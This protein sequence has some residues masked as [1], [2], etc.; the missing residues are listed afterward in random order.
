[1]LRALAAVVLLAALA[2]AP[3]VADT[4]AANLKLQVPP[5][6][7]DTVGPGGTRS[8]SWVVFALEGGPAPGSTLTFSVP[9]DV[10]VISLHGPAGAC[11]T[12]AAAVACPLGDLAVG[13]RVAVS[14]VFSSRGDGRK[15][16]GATAA[17]TA[18]EATPADNTGTTFFMVDAGRPQLTG[19]TV[20]PH[21]Y[22]KPARTA[23]RFT[24]SEAGTVTL[25][26]DS[27]PHRGKRVG[28]ACVKGTPRFGQACHYATPVAGAAVYR[29][30]KGANT[31]SFGTR[32][33]RKRLTA[34]PYVVR[35]S[36][37][38]DANNVGLQRKSSLK[39]LK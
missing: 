13:A 33:G 34:G 11:T 22:R 2:V 1:M 15:T 30:H 38:D 18:P 36:P 12:A 21:A 37:K 19:L 7:T 8:L 5:P 4:P 25:T 9:A 28:A 20:S 32:L 29:V 27:G 14:G 31:I 24:M 39:I 10:K 26:L 23:I 17:S 35:L 16:I 3:A 6:L